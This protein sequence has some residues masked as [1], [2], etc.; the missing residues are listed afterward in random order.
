MFFRGYREAKA[1]L[2]NPTKNVKST[3]HRERI[4]SHRTVLYHFVIA[5][6]R[7]K[8]QNPQRDVRA[9]N[10]GTLRGAVGV[11]GACRGLQ[12]H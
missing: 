4:A 3:P 2:H 8:K 6:W 10:V 1:R 9:S 5:V 7:A 12:N 11:D